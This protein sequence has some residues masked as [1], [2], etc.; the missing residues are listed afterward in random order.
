MQFL[1]RPSEN[2]AVLDWAG[3]QMHHEQARAH[4]EDGFRAGSAL[5]D[6][7]RMSSQ[8]NGN[9]W[10]LRS[11]FPEDGLWGSLPSS[12]RRYE[13]RSPPPHAPA[14]GRFIP[15]TVG[16]VHGT[17]AS[18]M[19]RIG[20]G[21]L[22]APAEELLGR[23]QLEG[24]SRLDERHE[25]PSAFFQAMVGWLELEHTEGF[26]RNSYTTASL[27]AATAGNEAWIWT[28]SPH[29]VATG[30]PTRMEFV[31]RDLRI[32]VLR[33]VGVV[34]KDVT[35]PRMEPFARA[36]SIFCIGTPQGYER[37][38]E[39]LGSRDLVALFEAGSLPFGPLSARS[40]ESIWAQDAAW[41]A[42][43]NSRVIILGDCE[44]ATLGL[45]SG[46]TVQEIP[47]RE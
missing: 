28:M 45:P 39:V 16:C 37:R 23:L 13:V 17:R 35:P 46:W 18:L 31:T 25:S 7:P 42:G 4:Q 44:E 5:D 27:L 30:S 9:V 32:P 33:D 12:M 20:G 24:P 15:A 3:T 34:R 8:H 11:E 21:H 1:S 41:K 29:G 47:L 36:S 2:G 40:L 14:G 10:E 6:A 38:R 26:L 22:V 43:E 19:V